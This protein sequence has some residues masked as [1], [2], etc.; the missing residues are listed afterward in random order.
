MFKMKLLGTPVLNTFD[1]FRDLEIDWQSRKARAT[2]IRASYHKKNHDI[3]LAPVPWRNVSGYFINFLC[4]LSL[5]LGN[6]F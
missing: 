6:Y 2:C 3:G 4:R 1:F 5:H